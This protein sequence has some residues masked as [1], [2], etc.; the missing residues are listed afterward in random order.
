MT[1]VLTLRRMDACMVEAGAEKQ[2]LREKKKKKKKKK[3]GGQ[4]KKRKEKKP[5]DKKTSRRKFEFLLVFPAK[6]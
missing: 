3:G 4:K 2:I 1:L 5:R 6:A